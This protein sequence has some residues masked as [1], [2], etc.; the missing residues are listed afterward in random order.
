MSLQAQ[1]EQ[2]LTEHFSPL[3]CEV[4]NESYQHSVP[5]GSETHFKAIIVS[6]AFQGMSRLARHQ[7]VY[8]VLNIELNGLI[9][10]L[11]VSAFAPSEWT[12]EVMASPQC[13]GGSRHDKQ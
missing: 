9:K 5:E 12:G 3:H 6:E 2:K 4:I 7:A 1:I 11:S 10:A 8:A 13:M